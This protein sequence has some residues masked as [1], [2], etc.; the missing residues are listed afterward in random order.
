M[1]F[2]V[3]GPFSFGGKG[4]ARPLRWCSRRISDCVAVVQ[5]QEENGREVSSF[6]G[7]GERGDTFL[8]TQGFIHRL[9][10]HA[11]ADNDLSLWTSCRKLKYLKTRQKK[12]SE[13]HI[14]PGGSAP[15]LKGALSKG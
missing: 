12:T 3:P 14:N 7:G 13:F 4:G 2:T 15:G 5:P 1:V 9:F 8:G 11:T 10:H 6:T